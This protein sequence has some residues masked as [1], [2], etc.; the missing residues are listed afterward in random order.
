MENKI[1]SEICIKCAECCKKYPFVELSQDEINELKKVT[2]LSASDFSNRKC[3]AVEEY[4]LD[5]KENGDCIFLNENDG[6]YSCGVYE[7][8]SV[9]CRTYPV[10][11]SQNDVCYL[12]RMK[13]GLLAAGAAQAYPYDKDTM[14][15]IL[16]EDK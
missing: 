16:S 12:N 10:S 15:R 14:L 3:R 1:T 8:R 13:K 7:V 2:G 11:K 4:F 5:F 6:K 9:I